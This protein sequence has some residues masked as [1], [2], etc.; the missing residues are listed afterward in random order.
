MNHISRRQSPR[1][2][3]EPHL[4]AAVDQITVKAR[5]DRSAVI[6]LGKWLD[7]E[8]GRVVGGIRLESTRDTDRKINLWQATSLTGGYG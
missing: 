2:V 4:R 6:T 3:D 1:Q 7:G 8:R 5:D